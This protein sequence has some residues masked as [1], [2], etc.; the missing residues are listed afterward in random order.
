MHS[1]ARSQHK[2]AD[3]CAETGE[4]GVEWLGADELVIG[5]ASRNSETGKRRPRCGVSQ[6]S[7]D[8]YIVACNDTVDELHTSYQHEEGHEDIQQ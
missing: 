6:G 7:E 2:L 3:R 1:Q 4:K 5:P 8:T